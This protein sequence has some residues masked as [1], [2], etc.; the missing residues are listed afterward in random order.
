MRRRKEIPCSSIV[1]LDDF[2]DGI[3]W[4]AIERFRSP[5]S[6]EYWSVQS[7][8]LLE[9]GTPSG[10]EL[11]GGFR[12]PLHTD[13]TIYTALADSHKNI[14]NQ[15]ILQ[16]FMDFLNL[17]HGRKLF[18]ENEW[19]CSERFFE[20]RAANGG[21]RYRSMQSYLVASSNC[22]RSVIDRVVVKLVIHGN[23]WSIEK[24]VNLSGFQLRDKFRPNLACCFW[25]DAGVSNHRALSA[26]QHRS[27]LVPSRLVPAKLTPV[28]SD[29]CKTARIA[30]TTPS[31][32]MSILMLMLKVRR[33]GCRV[34]IDWP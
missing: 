22:R 32:R 10:H 12:T 25:S 15:Q 20:K 7:L 5:L 14:R 18:Q 8:P 24:P 19:M 28:V 9:Q 27:T 4:T 33:I 16:L 2:L 29:F 13:S 26:S 17:D 6:F 34:L 3:N 23:G 21:N 1:D 31:S 30:R 11:L